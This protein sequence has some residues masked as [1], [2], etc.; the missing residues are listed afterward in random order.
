[1]T[2]W[3]TIVPNKLQTLWKTILQPHQGFS[4][5]T[6]TST[7]MSNNFLLHL[8]FSWSCLCDLACGSSV[9]S[10]WFKSCV[11]TVSWYEIDNWKVNVGDLLL[12]LIKCRRCLLWNS[13]ILAVCGDLSSFWV[14]S[15]KMQS[16][17]NFECEIAFKSCSNLWKSFDLSHLKG[18]IHT[19]W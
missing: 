13:R 12:H 4:L 11:L 1:M 14:I 17:T 16:G 5:A 10:C 18:C 9:C 3:C 8:I 7:H 6:H 2:C 19:D 15:I